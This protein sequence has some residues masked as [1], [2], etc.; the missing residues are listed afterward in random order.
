MT[1]RS[2]GRSGL[3]DGGAARGGPLP[4]GTRMPSALRT[5]L[6][7]TLIEMGSIYSLFR[8][9]QP[10]KKRRKG[11]RK[12]EEKTNTYIISIFM[13]LGENIILQKRG[14][15]TIHFRGQICTPVTLLL[16][17]RQTDI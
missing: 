8:S 11:E 17:Y 7:S 3:R 9:R 13:V 6:V 16:M 1:G 2:A 5:N 15:E 12:K 10:V 4:T 14:G